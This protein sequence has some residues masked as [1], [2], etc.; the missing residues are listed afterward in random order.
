MKAM[1]DLSRK[2]K[3]KR[4]KTREKNNQKNA[5]MMLSLQTTNHLLQP[6][7]MDARIAG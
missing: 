1:L 3:F 5:A 2:S 4:G 6:P 7:R